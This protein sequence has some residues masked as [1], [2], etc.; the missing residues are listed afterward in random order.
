MVLTVHSFITVFPDRVRNSP[1]LTVTPKRAWSLDSQ[2]TGPRNISSSPRPV[3]LSFAMRHANQP[4]EGHK[5]VPPKPHLRVRVHRLLRTRKDSTSRSV[6]INNP[7][8]NQP[9]WDSPQF[10][11]SQKFYYCCCSWG[12]GR[13]SWVFAK[14]PRI[15]FWSKAAGY[16]SL[17]AQEPFTTSFKTRSCLD[18]FSLS[19][20]N[21]GVSCQN[22]PATGN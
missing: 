14:K 22:L 18:F 7:Q 3:R 15:V 8:A 1:A 10:R 20:P 11:G 4:L 2:Q 19:L 6:H 16:L 12:R 21:A 13:E 5:V 17:S 9:Y